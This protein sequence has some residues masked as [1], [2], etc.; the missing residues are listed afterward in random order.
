M[1]TQRVPEVSIV[2]CTRDRGSKIVGTIES[3]IANAFANFE[4]IIIDQS[5]SDDTKIV[6]EPFLRDDRFRDLLTPVS[7]VCMYRIRSS[8]RK[9]SMTICV[10]SEV[11]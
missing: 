5:T 6:I 10:S 4:L 11:L 1:A 3:V 8:L 2:I 7:F 9:G